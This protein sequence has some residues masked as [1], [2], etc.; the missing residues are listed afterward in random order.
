MPT[1]TYIITTDICIVTGEGNPAHVPAYP[2][3]AWLARPWAR[4]NPPPALAGTTGTATSGAGV[5]LAVALPLSSG[6]T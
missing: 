5:P 4:L 3:A 6:G 2:T 1:D